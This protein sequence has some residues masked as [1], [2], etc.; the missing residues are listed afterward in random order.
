MPSLEN[1]NFSFDDLQLISPPHHAIKPLQLSLLQVLVINGPT[2]ASVMCS[3]LSN[4]TLPWLWRMYLSCSFSKSSNLNK[5]SITIGVVLALITKRNF[6]CLD[7]L[8]IS[9]PAFTLSAKLDPIDNWEAMHAIHFTASN[10]CCPRASEAAHKLMAGLAALP[11]DLTS[12]ITMSMS[13]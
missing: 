4:T 13:P 1:L 8:M 11:T 7:R 6:G 10:G 12:K 2:P 5:Y 9:E 3:F